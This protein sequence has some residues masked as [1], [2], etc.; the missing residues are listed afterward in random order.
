MRTNGKRQAE[1]LDTEA[2]EC[3]P[4][5]RRGL[6]KRDRRQDDNPTPKQQEESD[7]SHENYEYYINA[8]STRAGFLPMVKR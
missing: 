3:K 6:K 5:L 2:C 4:G 7:E 1:Q 8:A